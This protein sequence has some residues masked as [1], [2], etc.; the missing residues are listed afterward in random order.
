MYVGTYV[1]RYVRTYTMGC[2]QVGEHVCTCSPN[3]TPLHVLLSGWGITLGCMGTSDGGGQVWGIDTSLLN[4]KHF[5]FPYKSYSSSP[6][7]PHVLHLTHPC[8]FPTLFLLT[9]SSLSSSNNVLQH[10]YTHCDV[11]V[12]IL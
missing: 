7:S 2:C 1:R 10:I 8:Y 12:Y 11:F 4:K 6:L 3:L 9:L 5:R